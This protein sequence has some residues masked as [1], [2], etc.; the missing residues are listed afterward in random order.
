MEKMDSEVKEEVTSLSWRRGNALLLAV[1]RKTKV[2]RMLMLMPPLPA[3][4]FDYRPG[5]FPKMTQMSRRRCRH[6]R[7]ATA[8]RLPLPNDHS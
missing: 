6:H 1:P 2:S 3:S 5:L 7:N 8:Q 4:L